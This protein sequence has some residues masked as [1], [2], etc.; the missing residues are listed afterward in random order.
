MLERWGVNLLG[1]E[2]NFRTLVRV[3]KALNVYHV[4]KKEIK[5]R[6]DDDWRIISD[7]LRVVEGWDG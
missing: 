2:P 3:S 6:T 1:P 7:T 5:D 4:F